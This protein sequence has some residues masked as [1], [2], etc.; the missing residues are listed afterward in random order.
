MSKTNNHSHIYT[1]EQVA[2][3][4]LS[5]EAMTHKKLH[6]LC[7]YA[8]AWN[9]V[10]NNKPI[11]NNSIEAW[12]HGPVVKSLYPKYAGYAYNLIPKACIEQNIFDKKTLKTLCFVYNAYKEFDGDDLERF[13]HLEAPWLEARANLAPFEPCNNEINLQ[14]MKSFY[15]QQRKQL[16]S[17]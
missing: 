2:D 7:Y 4:F 1:A 13:T 12:V 8:Q 17:E 6:K 15:T 3:W 14:T 9:L 5:Q 16:L 11:F 10:L